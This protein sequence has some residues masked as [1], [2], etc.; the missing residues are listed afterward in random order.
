[1]RPPAPTTRC[2]GRL[3]PSGAVR[4][5]NP[6]CRARPGN[7]AARATDPYVVALPRGI[8]LITCQISSSAG[9]LKRLAGL[10][11]RFTGVR[12]RIKRAAWSLPAGR[13]C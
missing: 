7:P 11:E 3:S 12:C 9:S 2:H 13:A 6:T 4:S 1:M 10:R 8:V 5:A